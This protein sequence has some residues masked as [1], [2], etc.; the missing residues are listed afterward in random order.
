M[1]LPS[2]KCL[3]VFTSGSVTGLCIIRIVLARRQGLIAQIRRRSAATD[4]VGLA[5][6]NLFWMGNQ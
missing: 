5:I 2:D 4:T 1:Y 3:A 6:V